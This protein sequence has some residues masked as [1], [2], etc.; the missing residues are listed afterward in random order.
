MLDGGRGG[1]IQNADNAFAV[2]GQ[3]TMHKVRNINELKLKF[4]FEKQNKII[5]LQLSWLPPCESR[6]SRNVRGLLTVR[7]L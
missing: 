4:H 5:F 6:P 2:K 7:K 1:L 3:K